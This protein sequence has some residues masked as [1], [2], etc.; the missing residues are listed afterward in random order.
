MHEAWVADGA[1]YK[2]GIA[3]LNVN[4]TDHYLIAT[5]KSLGTVGDNIDVNFENGQTIPCIIADAKST[6]DSN[7]TTYG[8]GRS[9][10][11]VNI[12]E[13]EVDRNVYN[14]TG[15]PKTSTWGLEW[16]SSSDVSTVD[17]YGTIL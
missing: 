2:N 1:R 9:D 7:Y 16:D 6:N 15:N 4:G 11:S 10:G 8:H 12:L 14:S 13:F 17:N 3:V 5:A